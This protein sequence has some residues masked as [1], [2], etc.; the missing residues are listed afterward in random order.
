M[1]NRLAGRQ[2]R[3]GLAEFDP[4]G[5]LNPGEPAPNPG[6]LRL[7]ERRDQRVLVA[8]QMSKDPQYDHRRDRVICSA[9]RSAEVSI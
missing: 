9:G 4:F 1:L 8:R 5:R 7:G 6:L 3:Q 2:S